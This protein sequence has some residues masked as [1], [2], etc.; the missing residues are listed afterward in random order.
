MT[1]PELLDLLQ[2]I[3]AIESWSFSTG[4][5]LPDYLEE[6]LLNAVEV[7]RKEVMK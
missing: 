5:P 7:L 1:K 2:L 6:R 4:K 3:S